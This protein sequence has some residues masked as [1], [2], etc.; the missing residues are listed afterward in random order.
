MVHAG[1]GPELL[2]VHSVVRGIVEDMA[3]LAGDLPMGL[4]FRRE[5]ITGGSE[6]CILIKG[7]SVDGWQIHSMGLLG[8]LAIGESIEA[9]NKL[10]EGEIVW[11]R[12]SLLR[13][14]K[15]ESTRGTYWTLGWPKLPFSF[16]GFP[17]CTVIERAFAGS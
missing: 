3:M 10:V 7:G 12:N 17:S 2:T 1:V 16:G 13:G 8:F 15:W 14:S 4:R 5:A 9:A 6:R 11:K